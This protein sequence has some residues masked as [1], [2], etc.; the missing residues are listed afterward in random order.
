M[1]Y[2]DDRQNKIT[3]G[4][5]LYNTIESVID[6]ALK[7]EQVILPYEISVL[8]VDNEEIKN[9]NQDT[10]N[11]D[12]ETDVLSFPMLEYTEGKVFKEVYLNFD[13]PETYKDGYDLVLGDIVLSLEKAKEQSEDFG[14]SFLRE[15]CYLIVHSVLHLLGYDHMKEDEKV[16]M[17][18]QEENILEKLDIKRE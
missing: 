13:F 15:V 3:A 17:R 9:I 16:I 5:E 8:L 1:I 4:E 12:K 11:I 18:K 14:H 7:E 6:F 2:I 10:R